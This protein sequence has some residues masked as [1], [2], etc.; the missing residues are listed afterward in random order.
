VDA[1]DDSAGAPNL[2]TTGVP[3]R[4]ARGAALHRAVHQIV[5]H[6]R[7]FDDP[8]AVRILEPFAPGELQ[9][10]VDRR[11]RGMRAS[12]VLRSR[13][14]E[15]CLAEAVARGT[16]QYV[17]LGAGFDT[18][19]CRNPHLA[20]GL[21]VYEVD[22]PATQADKRRRIQAA[23]LAPRAGTHFVPIDF[24]RQTLS[25]ALPRAGFRFERPAFFSMLGVSIYISDAAVMATLRT[26]AACVPGS[27]ISMSFS[28]PDALLNPAARAYRQRS[29]AAMAAAGEPWTTFY[30]P[31]ELTVRLLQAGFASAQPLR[32]PEA[33]RRY[34]VGRNDGLAVADAHMMLARV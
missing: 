4:T 5:D 17:V 18:F 13:Y 31:D 32:P 10:L 15:D 33:N 29:I 6:P 12:I 11:G 16:R 24:E 30:D 27:E 9:S 7:V 25:E 19:A 14:T 22:H 3:S 23:G 21:Q 34:F 2:L 20:A 1:P 8:H 28:I 26:V